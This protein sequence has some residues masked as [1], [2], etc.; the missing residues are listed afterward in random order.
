VYNLW[1]AT[2]E[3]EEIGMIPGY[4]L[5]ILIASIIGV[6]MAGIKIKRSKLKHK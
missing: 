2:R 3:P 1:W 6:T 5:I 4:D